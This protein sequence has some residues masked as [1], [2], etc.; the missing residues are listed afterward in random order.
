MR[1]LFSAA[2]GRHEQGVD[3]TELVLAGAVGSH[4]DLNAAHAGGDD[5]ADIEEGQADGATGGLGEA[6]MAQPDAAQRTE[7]HISHRGQPP[8]ELVGAHGRRRGAVG[9]LVDLAFLDAVPP[10]RMFY[11]KS[12]ICVRTPPMCYVFDRMAWS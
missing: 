8:A 6:R 1:C 11:R 2:G 9:E 10:R 12:A 4:R 7:Q 5:G 3:L